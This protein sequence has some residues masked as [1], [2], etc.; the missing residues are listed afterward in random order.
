MSSLNKIPKFKIENRSDF[1][2]HNLSLFYPKLSKK[3]AR[4]LLKGIWNLYNT[5]L[6]AGYNKGKY[7]P[8][9]ED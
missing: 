5:A 4:N 6:K 9:F 8:D 7:F 1:I 3:E 2:E